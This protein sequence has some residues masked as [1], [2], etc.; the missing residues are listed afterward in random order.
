MGGLTD[1][2]FWGVAW[3]MFAAAAGFGLTVAAIAFSGRPDDQDLGEFD[4]G[5]N[6]LAPLLDQFT[7]LKN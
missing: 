2:G 5:Y 4:V 1:A 6:A 3:A 7:L